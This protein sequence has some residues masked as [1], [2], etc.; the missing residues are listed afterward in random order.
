MSNFFRNQRSK[1]CPYSFTSYLSA[2]SGKLLSWQGVFLWG[3]VGHVNYHYHKNKSNQLIDPFCRL[4]CLWLCW[5]CL[6][7]FLQWTYAR[8]Y[9][10]WTTLLPLCTPNMTYLL[11]KQMFSYSYT[12]TQYERMLECCLGFLYLWGN[13]YLEHLY[14]LLYCSIF[15]PWE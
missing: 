13:I 5:K 6:L 2:F 11:M 3:V 10:F 14:W 1:L 4:K 9:D 15:R 8:K 7:R 12:L